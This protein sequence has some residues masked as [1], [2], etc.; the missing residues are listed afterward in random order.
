MD[1]K[2]NKIQIA[3]F[4]VSSV[5]VKLVAAQDYYHT[6]LLRIGGELHQTEESISIL[7][8]N[9]FPPGAYEVKLNVNRKLAMVREIDFVLNDGK[10]EP[11][12][13]QEILY[14]LGLDL[15]FSEMKTFAWENESCIDTR[16]M[17]YVDFS[18]DWENRTLNLKVPQIHIDQK[19][20]RKAQ[21]SLWDNGINHFSMNYTFSSYNYSAQETSSNQYV[22]IR[23]RVNIGAWRF[24]NYS[25]W[26]RG[27]SR[28][29]WNHI[30][31]TASRNIVPLRSEMSLGDTYSSPSMFDSLKIRGLSMKTS[32]QM[33]HSSDRAYV[34]AIMGIANSDS[35]LTVVQNGNIIYQANVPAGPYSISDYYPASMGGDLTVSLRETDGTIKTTIVP[36]AALPVMEKKGHFKYNF[37]SGSL[38]EDTGPV[39]SQYVNQLEMVYGLTETNTVYGGVQASQDYKAVVLGVGSNLGSWGALAADVTRSSHRFQGGQT[40]SGKALKLNYAKGFQTST[41]LSAM[42]SRS[43][44]K[45]FARFRSAAMTGLDTDREK[46]LLNLSLS[47]TLPGDL[48]ALSMNMSRYELHSGQNSSTY[49]VGYSGTRH[50]ISYGVYLNKYRNISPYYGMNSASGGTS[51]SVTASIPLSMLTG[52]KRSNTSVSYAASRSEN[53]DMD[54]SVRLSGTAMDHRVSWGAY[55]GYGNHDVG[56]YGGVSA[57][58]RSGVGDFNAGY[59]YSGGGNRNFSYGGAGAVTV[60][61][62]GSVWSRSLHESNALVVAPHAKDV[63]VRNQASIVTNSQGLAVVPGLAS[64]R[65]NVVSLATDSIPDNV[66]IENN[67]V[68]NLYPTKGALI[69]AKFDTRLGYKT[70]FVIQGQ[71][72]PVGAKVQVVGSDIEAVVG[73]FNQLYV[74]APEKKG[75]MHITWMQDSQ[76]Q[77]CTIDFDLQETNKVGGLYVVEAECQQ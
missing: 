62:Y 7:S 17:E 58:Y 22:N 70:L 3:A 19:R 40:E 41:M 74:V 69:L 35:Q 24:Q 54:Q 38:Q 10:V 18:V 75:E 61:P 73:G 77:S 6:D 20:L 49:S 76:K 11:C 66:D 16:E 15:N 65:S 48:G 14:K 57:S 26:T 5:A 45:G 39:S 53:Q 44:D 52:S 46:A 50:G 51:V 30:S 12:I 63:H 31:T 47:Q 27:G 25:V 68:T 8:D 33:L 37:S 32:E 59:A 64:F 60:T 36:Y 2:I 4:L 13:N 9:E 21:E 72:I 28:S 55:Q 23:P 29:K 43:L 1:F 71:D 34:P 67:I 56:A 42:Y